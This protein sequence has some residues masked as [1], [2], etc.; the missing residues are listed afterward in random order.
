MIATETS[1]GLNITEWIEYG[2]PSEE[3]KEVVERADIDLILMLAHQEGRMEHFL[4]GRTNEAII[5]NLPAT[6]MLIK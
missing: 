1:E 4:F 3:I 6:L 2:K 5:R